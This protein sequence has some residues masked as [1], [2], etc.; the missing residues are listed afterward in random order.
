MKAHAPPRPLFDRLVPNDGDG[1]V[2]VTGA[3]GGLAAV[4]LAHLRAALD[5]PLVVVVASPERAREVRDG[6]SFYGSGGRRAAHYRA[7][8]HTPFLGMSPSRSHAMERT[9]TLFDASNRPA[10]LT[11][12]VVEAEALL[13]RVPPLSALRGGGWELRVGEFLDRDAFVARL[14]AAGYHAT[15]NVEEPG[16][17]ALRG[18][19][20]DLF[21]P[22]WT[23]PLRVDLWG[24]EIDSLKWFDPE[25]Q[26]SRPGVVEGAVAVTPARG[27]VL[28]SGE[29]LRRV[30]ERVMDLA[31]DLHVPTARARALAEDLESGII[32]VGAEDLLPLFYDEPLASFSEAFDGTSYG[33]VVEDLDRCS[34]ALER[35][36]SQL[37]ESNSAARA[38]ARMAVSV[39]RMYTPAAELVAVLRSRPRMLLEPFA[40]EGAAVAGRAV[41]FPAEDNRDV[42]RDIEAAMQ[43]GDEHILASLAQRIRGWRAQHLAVAV[44]AHSAGGAERLAGLLGHV[45]LDVKRHPEPFA[46]DRVASLAQADGDVGLFIG[47]P[48]RGFRSPQ[49]GLVLLDEA[50]ILGRRARRRRRRRF[51]AEAAL[52]SWRDLR[53]GDLIVH[54]SHG[55]GRYLGL[56]KTNV[57]SHEADFLVVEYAGNDKLYVPVE[58][59]HLVSKHIGAEA[60]D[61]ASSGR[62]DTLGGARWQATRR[63]VTKAVRDIADRLLKLYAERELQEGF[64]FSPPGEYFASFEAAFPY[65]ET[66]DQAKAIEDLLS[67]MQKPRPMDRVVCGDVGFGKT[68]VAMRAAFK[69]V[70]DGKQVAIL[71]PTVVLAEQHRL[72]LLRR[73][74]GFP[75]EIASY[76]RS[77]AGAEARRVRDR[78]ASG[79]IDIVVGTHK[80]LAKN[81]AFRDLGLLII[82]EEHRFG[83]T[84]KERLKEYRSDV[85]VLTLTATP[86]P[87]TL[88]LSM[89]GLRDLSLIQTPPAERLAVRTI[90]AQPSDAVIADAIERELARGGQV[91]FV[92]NRVEDLATKA[93]LIRRL[94]PRARIDVGHGQMERGHL[95][96]VMLRFMRGESN[97]LVC[98][99][100]IESGI[101]IPAAVQ[102]DQNG[103]ALV[104]MLVLHGSAHC[105][106]GVLPLG[107]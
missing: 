90:V 25:T 23:Y 79:A 19:I 62:L 73:F 8:D 70:L 59:L 28:P 86:I 51:S 38:Q 41:P 89:V 97:V 46:L 27:I 72:T 44:C 20:V 30:R 5:K 107:W 11:A 43:A 3:R 100:V 4:A 34:A 9:S 6:L 99:T 55:V 45:D 40:L 36:W 35:R 66:R 98:T 14:V 50:E 33:W 57:G 69:A 21:V 17:F 10:E 32:G 84:H 60:G 31:D 18:G 82:D 87:R 102:D 105:A 104:G 52:A 56:V 13:D 42:R 63:R 93:E 7:L 58:Q 47:E 15:E 48:G 101:D 103:T 67:D 37:V 76:T 95:E 71:V 94:V 64:A 24:D 26:R 2:V 78:L 54:L 61:S 53:E 81:I 83:V 106:C 49:L 96:A 39:E 91:F 85:D 77:K 22:H 75:V 92:H 16:S 65:E 12:L 88:H 68:E 1:P 29:A 80:L 74:R